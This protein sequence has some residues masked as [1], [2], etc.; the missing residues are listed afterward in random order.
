M[1]GK[2]S[3]QRRTYFEHRLPYTCTGGMLSE[4]GDY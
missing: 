4:A 3:K 2:I 1:K